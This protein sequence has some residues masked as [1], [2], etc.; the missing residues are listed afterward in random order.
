VSLTAVLRRVVGLLAA[1]ASIAAA[2]ATAHAAAHASTI[3][4]VGVFP[5]KAVVVVDGGPPRSISVGQTVGGWKLVSVGS[6]SAT[7]AGDAGRRTIGI[8][9]YV[10]PRGSHDRSTA[11]LAADD[12]GHFVAQGAVNGRATRFLVDTG[13]TIVVLSSAEADRLAIRY[14]DAPQ[15]QAATANGNAPYRVVK[16]DR[17]RVG[18][19]ELTNVDAAVLGGAYNGPNLLG[20]SFLSRTDV[21]RD[22]Q[23]MVLTRRF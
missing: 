14:R 2:H 15:A 11:V 3:D 21:S 19:I 1:G 18:E 10:A 22:G 13:A 23:N 7:F 16:L 17:I 4:V 9:S 6:D 20:M 8:G 5:D 12:R